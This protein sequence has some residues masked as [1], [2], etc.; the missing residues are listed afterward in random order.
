MKS[1]D[2]LSDATYVNRVAIVRIIYDENDACQALFVTL[3][4]L[5][6]EDELNYPEMYDRFTK[7]K[8]LGNMS[9]YDI[10]GVPDKIYG[11]ISQGFTAH[12]WYS[13]LYYYVGA[14]NYYNFYFCSLDYGRRFVSYNPLNNLTKVENWGGDDEIG[15]DRVNDVCQTMIVSDRKEAKPNTYGISNLPYETI[16]STILSFSPFDSRALLEE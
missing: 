10:A 1:I 15:Q 11:N 9:F 12:A 13:E 16:K 6:T 14:G 5:G 7:S 8:K 2:G 3:P 4:E